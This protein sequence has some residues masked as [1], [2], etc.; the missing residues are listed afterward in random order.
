MKN[1][2]VV[3][4]FN[5]SAR[6][7]F[8]EPEDNNVQVIREERRNEKIKRFYRIADRLGE[9]RRIPVFLD[10]FSPVDILLY[11][12]PYGKEHPALLDWTGLSKYQCLP[13]FVL[14]EAVDYWDWR[15]ISAYQALS[16]SFIC[17]FQDY[18]C[19]KEICMFQS[20]S[21][22]FI[23][24]FRDCVDWNSISQYQR[25]SEAAIEEFRHELNLSLV[26]EHQDLSPALR[27]KIVRWS[28]M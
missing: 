1:I 25:L 26:L 3:G 12:I 8:D 15:A 19:W 14:V 18:V 17:R 22:E 2:D 7:C 23:R 16:E 9:P 10:R 28:R 5:H 20:L 21:T 11:V 13:E 24:D 4:T 6:R 27:A